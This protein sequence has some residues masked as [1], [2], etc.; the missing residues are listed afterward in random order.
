MIWD[1]NVWNYLM[2]SVGQ[3]VIKGRQAVERFCPARRYS[4]IMP[5]A[6]TLLDRSVSSVKGMQEAL[7]AHLKR[8]QASQAPNQGGTRRR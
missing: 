3:S 4:V 8:A 5:A 2:Q 6:G 7:A 1:V